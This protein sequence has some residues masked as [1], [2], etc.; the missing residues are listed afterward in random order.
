MRIFRFIA[1]AITMFVA[2]F[3]AFAQPAAMSINQ[4]VSGTYTNTAMA[5]QGGAFR[6][7]FQENGTG[8]ASGVRNWQFNADTYF[9]TW[10][11]TAAAGVQTL[12]S[13]NTIIAPN[14]A[15]ASGNF[16]G[17]AGYNSNGRLPATLASNYYTYNITR[18]TSYASQR[19]AV[20]QTSYNPVTISSVTAAPGAYASRTVT[21]TTSAAPA[22]GENIYV[23]FSTNSY[24]S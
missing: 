19:M 13:Y 17:G 12:A 24:T 8:T 15:T 6:A 9:N 18:G 2:N 7:R 10:G 20:L 21:I 3:S 16:Q 23:R 1:L 11:T 14:S 22:A 5:L 4:D